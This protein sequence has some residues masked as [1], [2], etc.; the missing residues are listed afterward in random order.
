[1]RIALQLQQQMT[2]MG[3]A[4]YPNEGCGIFL[5]TPGEDPDVVEV[6][7]AT[8]LRQDRT[9][10]RYVMDPK[11]IMLAEREAE[12]RGL[13]VLG[14]WHTHP[15]HPARPSQYDADH[16]WPE[17]VYVIMAIEAGKLAEVTAWILE[18]ETPPV[19]AETALSD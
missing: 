13:E 6:R 7:L 3:E 19:F 2:A 5:G 11:D 10:D 14:F 18:S 15:D 1:M 8:N 16:A 9:R 12:A 17:Y 4:A